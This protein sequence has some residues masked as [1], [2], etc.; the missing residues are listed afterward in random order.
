MET[1]SSENIKHRHVVLWREALNHKVYGIGKAYG[2]KDFDKILQHYSVSLF[3]FVSWAFL[4]LIEMPRILTVCQAV[5]DLPCVNFADELV[6]AFPKA[7]VVL[8]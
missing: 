5:S 1:G 6:S 3:S 8:K 2:P 7:K 4:Q